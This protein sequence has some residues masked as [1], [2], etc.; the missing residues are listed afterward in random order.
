LVPEQ[1][2]LGLKI[3]GVKAGE[4]SDDEGFVEFVAR[5][6]VAGKG[7]RLHENSRFLKLNGDWYYVD[8]TVR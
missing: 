4:P 8:G 5:Y 2:W 1:H 7:Y 6:K 3:K